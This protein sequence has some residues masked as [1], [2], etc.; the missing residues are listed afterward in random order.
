MPAASR[1]K[2]SADP[3]GTPNG[4][5]TNEAHPFALGDRLELVDPGLKAHEPESCDPEPPL[6]GGSRPGGGDRRARVRVQPPAASVGV[7]VGE[8]VGV[9]TGTGTVTL[10]RAPKIAVR[11]TP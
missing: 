5:Q 9:G 10:I 7:G 6:R 2:G 1:S 11:L 8:G 4:G 3:P